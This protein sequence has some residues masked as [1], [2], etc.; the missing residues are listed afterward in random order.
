L[1]AHADEMK[2]PNAGHHHHARTQARG[3]PAQDE[4][5]RLRGPHERPRGQ[6]AGVGNCRP[7]P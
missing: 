4:Q 7:D 2:K 3:R 6:G 1:Q 5:R